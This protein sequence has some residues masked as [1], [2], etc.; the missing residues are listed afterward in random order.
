[1]PPQQLRDGALCPKPAKRIAAVTTSVPTGQRQHLRTTASVA[2]PQ[3]PGAP[4]P[5]VTR[6]VVA[7]TTRVP[8]AVPVGARPAGVVPTPLKSEPIMSYSSLHAMFQSS[9]YSLEATR[10]RFC[11]THRDHQ[12]DWPAARTMCCCSV[13]PVLRPVLHHLIRSD[14]ARTPARSSLRY[15]IADVLS[16]S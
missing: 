11:A 3:R 8:S 2:A 4:V 14:L 13:R 15:Y 9:G 16:R 5:P 12:H 1:L 6:P 10:D 7:S